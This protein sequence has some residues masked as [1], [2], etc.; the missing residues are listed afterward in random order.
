MRLIL[1]TFI[2][3]IA[4]TFIWSCG[5]SA[6]K[7]SPDV[8]IS[9]PK[10]AWLIEH[11][12]N[13]NY[14][15]G[16]GSA[17]KNQYGAEAQKSAQDLALADLASQI[18]VK[19]TSDIVT[20]LI[21]RGAIT[22]DEYLATARSEAMADLE[23]HELVD[24]WQDGNYQYAYYRLS[25]AQYA[26]I[27]ARKRE[28]ALAMS[29][30]FLLKARAA[31][32][33]SNFSESFNATIQAFIPLLPYLN[34]ALKVEFEGQSII[35]SNEINTQLHSLLSDIELSP[36]TS[37]VSAKLGQPLKSK[38][39]ITAT[40]GDG[41]KLRGLPLSAHFVK[42]SGELVASLNTGSQGVATL[43]VTNITAALKLQV[44]QVS[45]DL[46][47]LLA[48]DISPLL[49]S[50]IGSIPQASTRIILDVSNPTIYLESSEVYNGQA[51]K[52]LQIEPKLK[53]HFITQGFHFVDSPSQ[54]DWQMT[55]NATASKGTE[56]S[57]MFTSFADV[58]LNVID[59]N[60]GNEIYKNSLSRVKGIDLSYTNATNKAFNSAADKMIGTILPEIL[61]SIK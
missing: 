32:D 60:T 58:S 27:Q 57:G 4:L 9:G 33:L 7:A 16:I 11:P 35:L 37:N 18:T 29:T 50:I 51:R 36:N 44:I 5:S 31:N 61:E 54:A 38:L 47:K 34:E 24:T 56:Y 46:E 48:V 52:Q 26:A 1:R 25:K 59:R 43:Q 17:S 15:I 8:A 30:D 40:Q 55:L 6:P 53:N 22:E 41:K 42:G 45:V 23:G 14:Y 10:P 49:T 19:I 13:P 3:S 2:L 20:T 28:S 12:V 21:E 39:T